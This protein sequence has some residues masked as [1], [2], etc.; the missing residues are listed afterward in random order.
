MKKKLK[1]LLTL[2]VAATLSMGAV[3][4]AA[5]GD[6]GEHEHQWSEPETQTAATCTETGVKIRKCLVKG[7]KETQTAT[8]KAK[9]HKFA[10]AEVVTPATCTTDGQ[11]EYICS[12]CDESELR[13]TSK[14]GHSLSNATTVPATCTE[15]GHLSGTCATC[16]DAIEEVIPAMGHRYDDSEISYPTFTADG[17]EAGHCSVCD[18]DVSTV[19]PKLEDGQYVTFRFQILRNSGDIIGGGDME[20]VVKDKDGKVVANGGG[21]TIGGNPIYGMIMA[22]LP[23]HQNEYYTMTVTGLPDNFSANEASVS[24]SPEYPVGEFYITANLISQNKPAPKKYEIGSVM[25]DLKMKLTDGTNTTLGELLA[26]NKLV[27]LNFFGIECGW[28]NAEFPGLQAAYDNY[29]DKGI[30]VVVIAPYDEFYKTY[31]EEDV[32]AHME[33]NGYTIPTVFAPKNDPLYDLYMKFGLTGY[34]ASILIDH[35]GVVN[36]IHDGAMLWEEDDTTG[37]SCQTAF[38]YFFDFFAGFEWADMQ[39]TSLS[40]QQDGLEVSMLRGDYLPVYNED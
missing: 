34:P 17:W 21:V 27:L 11:S 36:Y 26:K 28:C 13:T 39:D 37:S 2:G 3:A 18:K 23:V 40:A 5:C 14:F 4:F 32:I 1:R 19:L 38:E 7:C 16:G 31:S 10:L 29:K 12:R 22:S 6:V 15:D 25:Q 20:I 9:G 33:A 30:E 24:V 8:I 35:E